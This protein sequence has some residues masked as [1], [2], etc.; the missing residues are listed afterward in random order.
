M[1][2][3]EEEGQ[4]ERVEAAYKEASYDYERDEDDWCGVK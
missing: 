2:G 3:E 4:V 1:E